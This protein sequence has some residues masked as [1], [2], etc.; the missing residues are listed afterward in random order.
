MDVHGSVSGFLKNSE[1]GIAGVSEEDVPRSRLRR[2]AD[3]QMRSNA[4]AALKGRRRRVEDMVAI[5]VMAA[6]F[7][8]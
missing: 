5:C 1:I 6:A 2:Q 8:L 3:D 7:I 4:S